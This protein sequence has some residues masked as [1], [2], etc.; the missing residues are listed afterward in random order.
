MRL[1]TDASAWLS[2]QIEV[3]ERLLRWSV[4]GANDEAVNEVARP[5]IVHQVWSANKPLEWL[6]LKKSLGEIKTIRPNS[7]I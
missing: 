2:N 3:L 5:H 6:N 1:W 4:I 7:L